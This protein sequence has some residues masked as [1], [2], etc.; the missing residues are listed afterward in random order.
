MLSLSTLLPEA[1]LRWLLTCSLGDHL[2][3]SD[4][5]RAAVGRDLTCSPSLPLP[6]S[7]IRGQA[8]LAR[9][10]QA[11]LISPQTATKPN[12]SSWLRGPLPP[13]SACGASL[14][15]PPTTSQ[16][17]LPSH[18]ESLQPLASILDKASAPAVPCGNG[19]SPIY[20]PISPRGGPLL[21][22]RV[23][24]SACPSVTSASIGSVSMCGFGLSHALPFRVSMPQRFDLQHLLTPSR[25]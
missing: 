3:P 16:S 23:Q 13:S 1:V 25:L 8:V 5:V 2:P 7:L 18:S 6:V 4:P 14:L 19:P 22:T 9:S 24:L 12:A 17:L 20:P 11:H 21:T 15:C 10:P